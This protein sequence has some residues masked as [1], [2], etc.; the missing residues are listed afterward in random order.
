[1][2]D[3]QSSTKKKE[4]DTDVDECVVQKADGQATEVKMRPPLQKYCKKKTASYR[5]S[6]TE[7]MQIE[8]PPEVADNDIEKLE[9]IKPSKDKLNTT[10]ANISYKKSSAGLEKKLKKHG[11]SRSPTYKDLHRDGDNCLKALI[12]QMSQPGQ[13]FKV[14]DRDDYSF[15]RWYIAKQLEIHVSAG[16]A[17]HYVRPSIGSPQEYVTQIQKDEEFVNNDF[18]FSVAKVFNKDIIIIDS[19][20]PTKEVTYIKGGPNDMN[21]KGK[22]IFLGH[23]PKEDAGNDFYQ[24]IVPN[25]DVSIEVIVSSLQE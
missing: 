11:F 5:W 1:M 13:D 20:N 6:G 23:L 22:P 15:L 4:L 7:M 9:L 18:L 10:R 17:D 3:T 2:G 19:S 12:D 25:E 21:G 24:S 14:W 8:G 16:K